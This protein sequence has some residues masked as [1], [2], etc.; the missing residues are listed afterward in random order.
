MHKWDLKKVYE[1][2]VEKNCLFRRR[3]RERKG[4]SFIAL[5]FIELLRKLWRKFQGN[6]QFLLFLLLSAIDTCVRVK[7][8]NIV[9]VIHKYWGKLKL[10]LSLPIINSLIKFNCFMM[11]YFKLSS[12][13]NFSAIQKIQ[14]LRSFFV[15]ATFYH[16]WPPQIEKKVPR[17]ASLPSKKRNC[18]NPSSDLHLVL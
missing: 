3:A 12:C 17:S 13:V 1:T 9:L 18:K 8:C 14:F 7:N 15:V 2:Q 10:Y 6:S 4:G 16:L 11:K 5:H